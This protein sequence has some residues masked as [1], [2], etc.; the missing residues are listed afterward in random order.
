MLALPHGTLVSR[1]SVHLDQVIPEYNLHA[2]SWLILVYASSLLPFLQCLDRL[3]DQHF[4]SPIMFDLTLVNDLVAKRNCVGR[5]RGGTSC[6]ERQK[7]L[8]CLQREEALVLD[9]KKKKGPLLQV[10]RIQNY[11]TI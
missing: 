7:F 4:P 5:P 6:L 1:G 11:L 10:Q 3:A 8:H 9:E 2:F